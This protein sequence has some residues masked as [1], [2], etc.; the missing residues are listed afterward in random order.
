MQSG[1]HAT[2]AE[3]R[4]TAPAGTLVHPAAG[5]PAGAAVVVTGN[6]MG[7]ARDG[8]FATHL[9]TPGATV[10]PRPAGLDAQA[11]IGIAGSAELS[12]TVHPF[13]LRGATLAGDTSGR[14]IVVP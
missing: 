3:E 1:G 12:T 11:A 2:V 4:G 10:I 13:I 6:G 5:L 7:E 9:R 8:S 14:A